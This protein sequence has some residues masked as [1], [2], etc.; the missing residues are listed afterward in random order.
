MRKSGG[1]RIMA[2]PDETTIYCNRCSLYN[3]E[4][5]CCI[6][7]SCVSDIIEMWAKDNLLDADG[8]S[9]YLQGEFK[10]DIKE[11]KRRFGIVEVGESE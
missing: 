3:I 8:K 11:L 6:C 4:A 5:E 1:R 7:K 2:I 10:K 9:L